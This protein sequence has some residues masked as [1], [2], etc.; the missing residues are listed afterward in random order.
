MML[1][2]KKNI[3]VMFSFGRISMCTYKGPPEC[4]LQGR[5]WPRPLGRTAPG[6]SGR[7]R[8]AARPCKLQRRHRSPCRTRRRSAPVQKASHFIKKNFTVVQPFLIVEITKIV[9]DFFRHWP[10]P[11]LL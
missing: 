5:E 3:D 9:S 10:F 4:Q 11:F 1:P 2:F 7:E 8:A 6:P